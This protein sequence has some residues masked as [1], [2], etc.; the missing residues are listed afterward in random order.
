M[1]VLV[2]ESSTPTPLFTPTLKHKQDPTY[3]PV[4]SQLSSSMTLADI[5]RKGDSGLND[6]LGPRY[7]PSLPVGDVL[8]PLQAIYPSIIIIGYSFV[9]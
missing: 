9:E 2:G 3:A 1:Q 4:T 5:L 8:D 6:S 7:Y